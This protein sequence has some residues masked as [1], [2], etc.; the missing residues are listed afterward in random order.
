M[1]ETLDILAQTADL[2]T[3]LLVFCPDRLRQNIK[4]LRQFPVEISFAV[5]SNYSRTVLGEIA[6]L[7]DSF[8]VQSVWE[9]S[10]IPEGRAIR[11]HSPL[12]DKRILR[13]DSLRQVTVN[14]LAQATLLSEQAPELRWGCRVTLPAVEADQFIS[15]S[16]K[17]G[18]NIDMLP[19]ILTEALRSGRPCRYLHHHSIS[20]LSNPTTARRLSQE[21][22]ALLAR[23][24]DPVVA[25]MDEVCIGGGLDGA[26]ELSAKGSAVADVMSALLAP[27]QQNFAQLRVVIEPG[28]YLVEDSCFAVTTVR[29]VGTNATGLVAVV[30]IGTGFLVPLPAARFRLSNAIAG[31]GRVRWVDLVD[32]SCS[33]NGMISRAE[34]DAIIASGSRL[35]I[36]NC[37]AYT[38]SCSGPYLHP[39]PPLWVFEDKKLRCAVGQADLE[40]LSR[41]I[42]Y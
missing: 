10:L 17:F 42:L 9:A 25:A 12:L 35:L 30:D 14:S 27:I 11:F 15:T 19:D 26:G 4:K 37:G 20:R 21:F 3:P 28:R 13:W 38:F 6:P 40:R 32:A 2:E 23:L 22:C 5:K 36:E 8:D 41:E 34:T 31:Q 1:S 16:D 24:P 29:E 39:L 18:I 7:V 33:P